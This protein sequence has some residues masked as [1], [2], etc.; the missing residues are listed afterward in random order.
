MT[1]NDFNHSLTAESVPHLM[2]DDAN[3]LEL[4]GETQSNTRFDI[5][6]VPH[7]MYNDANDLELLG[8]THSNTRFDLQRSPSNV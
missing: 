5:Q 3:N 2:S 8:E 7:L 1:L 4:V 6:S